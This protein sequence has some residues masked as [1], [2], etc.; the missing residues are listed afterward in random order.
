MEKRTLLGTAPEIAQLAKAAIGAVTSNGD[1]RSSLTGKTYDSD[2]AATALHE[3][4]HATWGLNF[5]QVVD[6]ISIVPS[7]S[8]DDGYI[9]AG[10]VSFMRTPNPTA[11]SDCRLDSAWTRHQLCRLLSGRVAESLCFGYDYPGMQRIS[12]SDDWRFTRL[13]RCFLPAEQHESYSWQLF[14]HVSLLLTTPASLERL[15][16]VQTAILDHP[17]GLMSGPQV[18]AL[19]TGGTCGALHPD[20]PGVTCQHQAH[21]SYDHATKEWGV[22]P[23]GQSG[24]QVTQW[25]GFAPESGRKMAGPRSAHFRR[26]CNINRG[27]MPATKPQPFTVEEEAAFDAASA[28]GSLGRLSERERGRLRKRKLLTVLARVEARAAN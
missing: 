1:F 23:N 17:K 21:R 5:G 10:Y 19:V 8:D 13:L 15:A 16:T 6:E 4:G 11:E 25:P 7:A 20:L 28:D 26:L 14:D 3:A 22:G 2:L 27:L 12:A 9:C 24:W 18:R